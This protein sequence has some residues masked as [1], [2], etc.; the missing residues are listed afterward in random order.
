MSGNERLGSRVDIYETPSADGNLAV[1]HIE[2]ALSK[3]CSLLIRNYRSNRY[4][5]S[6]K[7]GHSA[8]KITTCRSHLSGRAGIA[9]CWS[10][11]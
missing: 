10:N 11:Q 6:K 8:A 2:A 7:F 5:C 4:S 9:Q 1:A 3:Q